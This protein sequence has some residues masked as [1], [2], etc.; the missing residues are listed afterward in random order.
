MI[1][2][3]CYKVYLPSKKEFFNFYEL[4]NKEYLAILKF[5]RN[6]DK[7]NLSKYLENLITEKS[8]DRIDDLHRIDKYCIILTMIIV[9]VKPVFKLVGTCDETDNTYD[10]HVNGND[11]LDKISNVQYTDITSHVSGDLS[12]HY[13]YP[14]DL[15]ID[16][17]LYT[18]PSPRDRG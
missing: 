15:Y 1:D 3:F 8:V 18:S 2:R 6:N 13:G 9:S 5:N 16:C 7:P 11:I 14:D 12:I 10:I 4:N 17:L